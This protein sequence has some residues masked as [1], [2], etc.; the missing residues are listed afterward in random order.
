[1]LKIY[2]NT[3]LTFLSLFFSFYFLLV[4]EVK[5]IFPPITG[6]LQFYES[7]KSDRNHQENEFAVILNTHSVKREFMRHYVSIPDC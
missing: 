5:V 2:N 1:M 6:L 4:V 3:T 7:C